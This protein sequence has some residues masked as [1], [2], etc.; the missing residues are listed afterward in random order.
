MALAFSA[1]VSNARLDAIETAI[2]VTPYL[3]VYS[4]TAPADCATALS[5]NT[6][7]AE[8][9]LPSDW[10]LAAV[11]NF[12][13]GSGV[14]WW[15]TLAN[16]TGTASFFRIYASDGVT[17]HMQG[18]ITGTG[19]G[20]TI[21]FD[22]VNITANDAVVISAFYIRSTDG[23]IFQGTLSK[24]LGAATVSAAGTVV[25]PSWTSIRVNQT[26]YTNQ[27]FYRTA[28]APTTGVLITM[29]VQVPTPIT[30]YPTSR[31]N[32]EFVRI[33]FGNW[34]I[35]AIC[36][37]G[38]TNSSSTAVAQNNTMLFCDGTAVS[39]GADSWA[40]DH[41]YWTDSGMPVANI[42]GWVFCAVQAS[43]DGSS[44]ITLRQWIRYGSGSMSAVHEDIISLSTLRSDLQTNAAWTSAHA[45]AY[46]PN[47]TISGIQVNG[48]DGSDLYV[49]SCRVY[50]QTTDPGTTALA[51]IANNLAADTSAW[52]DWQLD[53]TGSPDLTDRSGN[54]RALTSAGG[55]V[56]AGNTYP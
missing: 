43:I 51:A 28:S 17:C 45:N 44:N 32:E 23:P 31:G 46:T 56:S 21:T 35:R 14:P 41:T 47:S 40:G 26:Q 18:N 22:N 36:M 20:G 16:A 4:G 33:N 54:S 25:T 48:G 7:L 11:Y 39:E 52:A 49:T 13:A 55:T 5:G 6:L 53:W 34:Y 12:K 3:R 15:D 1:A 24:T 50:D 30:A 38:T 8:F 10:L 37:N 9:V 42:N 27:Y 2:G 19:G 29:W